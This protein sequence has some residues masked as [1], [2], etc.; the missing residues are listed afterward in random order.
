[1][2]RTTGATADGLAGVK[3]FLVTSLSASADQVYS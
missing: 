3:S 1:M 2:T